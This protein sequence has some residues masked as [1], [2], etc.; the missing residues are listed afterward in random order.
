MAADYQTPSAGPGRLHRRFGDTDGDRDV[1]NA[2][3]I[4][5]RQALGVPANYRADLDFDGDRD[6]DNADFIR[7]RQRLGTNQP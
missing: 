2:D 3:F 5:F 1:D 6:V 7:F 4:R